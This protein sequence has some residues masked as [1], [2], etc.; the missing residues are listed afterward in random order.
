MTLS[1]HQPLPDVNVA[2]AWDHVA[3]VL[4]RR[5]DVP[6]FEV[7]HLWSDPLRVLL[8]G[9]V[10]NAVDAVPRSTRYH[11]L[12]SADWVTTLASVSVQAGA[13]VRSRELRREPDGTWLLDGEP[14]PR[15]RGLLDV[16]LGFTPS[17]NTLPVRRLALGV[18]DAADVTA[19]WMRFPDL[20]VEPLAQRYAHLAPRHYRYESAGGSFRASL[21]V[22]DH[23]LV[24]DYEGLFERAAH[25]P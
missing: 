24:A 5:L 9:E 1:R 18:G 2:G 23:G 8:Q 16:D 11:V 15:L 10:L 17:T 13:E 3:S 22:D 14:Q 21:E 4:W 7:C 25:L 20:T 6:G 12:C 19:A